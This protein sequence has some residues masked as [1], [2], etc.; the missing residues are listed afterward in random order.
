MTQLKPRLRR[1]PTVVCL[2]TAMTLAFQ[3]GNVR[4]AQASAESSRAVVEGFHTV[5]LAVMKEA[6]ALN[7]KGRFDRLV[8]AVQEAFNLP[9]MVKVAAGIGWKSAS[10]SQRAEMVAAF[11]RMTAGTY[12]SRFNGFSGQQFKTVAERP[13]PRNMILVETQI[14][15]PGGDPVALTYLTRKASDGWRIVDIL[16]DGSI[17]E[18]AVRRSEYRQIVKSG[19]PQGLTSI[20]NQTAE[21]L[22][23]PR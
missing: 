17:S 22:L 3:I 6:K 14:I 5:L 23:Q 12:A 1:L 21:K 2:V 15:S 8:P 11:T 20:L 18:L 7:V 16:L 19:G 13:G 10:E 9:L 4:P